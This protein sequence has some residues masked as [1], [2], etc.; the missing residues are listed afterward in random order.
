MPEG[1]LSNTPIFFI[2]HSTAFLPLE[3]L[4]STLALHLE[5]ISNSKITNKNHKKMQKN[6]HDHEKDTRVQYESWTKKAESCLVPPQLGMCALGGSN[7]LPLYAYP[8][9]TATAPLVLIWGLQINF[10]K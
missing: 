5:A 8:L 6:I 9:M 7:F 4:D 1:S 10:S 2:R 3:T